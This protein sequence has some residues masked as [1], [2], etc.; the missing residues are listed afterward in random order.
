M[1]RLPFLVALFF[2]GSAACTGKRGED[3][4]AIATGT[5]VRE[6]VPLCTVAKTDDPATSTVSCSAGISN[7]HGEH[8]ITAL[9]DDLRIGWRAPEPLGGA[10]VSHLSCTLVGE[11]RQDCAVTLPLPPSATQIRFT[12]TAEN[13]A[14]K[15]SAAKS[16]D[17]AVPGTVTS[18]GISPNIA[19]SFRPGAS[20][21]GRGAAKLARG[22][23]QTT[24]DF[25]LTPLEF[26]L[27]DSWIP[28]STH[29][30]SAICGLHDAQHGQRMF[31]AGTSSIYEI[32]SDNLV[33]VFSG[34]MGRGRNVPGPVDSPL[35]I[36]Y[37][38]PGLQ[39][40]C[41]DARHV[42]FA[43]FPDVDDMNSDP[44]RFMARDL[45]VAR[46]QFA[47]DG[48][49]A[50][51]ELLASP[52]KIAH[53][54]GAATGP[55]GSLYVLD[56]FRGSLLRLS[57]DGHFSVFVERTFRDVIPCPKNVIYDTADCEA[58]DGG[59]ASDASGALYVGSAG[60][61]QIYRVAARG[62]SPAP[63]V[64]LI[65]G[66]GEYGTE[67]DGGPAKSAKLGMV[68][69][70]LA[71]P[72][73][74]GTELLFADRYY[75]YDTNGN[76]RHLFRIRKI[77]ATGSVST[78]VGAPGGEGV[79]YIPIVGDSAPL[80]LFTLEY[81]A[82]WSLG[83][84]DRH[85][86]LVGQDY[87]GLLEIDGPKSRG[88]VVRL[89][90]AYQGW[91]SWPFVS[92]GELLPSG[93]VTRAADSRRLTYIGPIGELGRDP[94]GDILMIE[95]WPARL[96][97]LTP[98]RDASG[99]VRKDPETG[100]DQLVVHVVAG[101][102]EG[103]N[104]G[105]VQ[106]N[107]LASGD[108]PGPATSHYLQNPTGFAVS[109]DG[110]YFIAD[111]GNNRVRRVDRTGTLTTIAGASKWVFR[112]GVWG[113]DTAGSGGN[114]PAEKA[115]LDVPY[116]IARGQ[117]GH[118]YF[119]EL[120][121]YRVRELSPRPDGGYLLSTVA[122][123]GALGP[124]AQDGAP[125]LGATFQNPEGIFVDRAGN[126]L[127]T[128]VGNDAGVDAG[129]IYRIGADKRLY[130]VA[131]GGTH[132][133]S[134]FVGDATAMR[135]LPTEIQPGEGGT[136]YVIDFPNRIVA[137]TPRADGTYEGRFLVDPPTPN[138]PCGTGATRGTGEAVA[139]GLLS[140]NL[141]SLC[142]AP[143]T[144]LLVTNACASGGDFSLYLA[145][146]FGFGVSFSTLIHAEFPC[147]K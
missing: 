49:L 10:Q 7:E 121:G 29:S 145:R 91:P 110:E 117:N 39:I 32:G 59:L 124:F 57:A 55:D 102:I 134:G 85:G 90:G 77:D 112:N 109:P 86:L 38:Y 138:G 142:L 123:K 37:G 99:A 34:V 36:E 132:A 51:T 58:S 28:L 119:T 98:N 118:L 139:G 47:A 12:I 92:D 74:G 4:P 128:A 61:H 104:F 40:A 126:V 105:L 60:Q 68:Q 11:L 116:R 16:R 41:D 66:T 88:K 14:T 147:V 76:W 48:T 120:G 43:A 114:G 137:L 135:L 87:G 65:A 130:V 96:L 97:R 106:G 45:W 108:T 84:S 17:V 89:A 18:Y 8:P 31:I 19:Y 133:E 93:G 67:G 63:E 6:I 95:R 103:S 22:A 54:A 46:F 56:G 125:A 13:T 141:G 131:G 26:K 143:T 146:V 52:L 50:K 140:A 127:F 20:S 69:S 144:A 94:S 100:T 78:Y 24:Q 15:E 33:H 115:I 44:A 5:N 9:G 111:A 64:T 79:P 42:L 122:G 70:V 107:D 21:G 25:G 35:A 73:T 129:R 23:A 53:L 27:A 81:R 101:R 136:I 113:W 30:G 2:V 1:K 72:G 3:G 83:D 80:A 71:R 62:T 82:A 75:T